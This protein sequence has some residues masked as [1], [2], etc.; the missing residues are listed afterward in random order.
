MTYEVEVYLHLAKTVK[1]EAESLEEAKE[2]AEVMLSNGDIVFDGN[3]LGEV[4]GMG[5]DDDITDR[6]NRVK[7]V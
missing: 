5:V 2:T 7:E 4:V 6:M 1:V 3:W